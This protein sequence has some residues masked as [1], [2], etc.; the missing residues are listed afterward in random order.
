M[1]TIHTTTPMPITKQKRYEQTPKGKQA[2]GR[3][4][5]NYDAK[6]IEWKTRLEPEMSAALERVK[7]DELSRSAF[8]KKIFQEYLDSQYLEQ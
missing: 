3:A 8:M 6:F 4:T 7:P 1:S 5:A 2:R